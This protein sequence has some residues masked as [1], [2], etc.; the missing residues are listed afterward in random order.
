MRH[1]H[2]DFETY[3]ETDIKRGLDRY[4]ADPAF[5]ILMCA[6]A[7]DQEPVSLIDFTESEDGILA[8]SSLGLALLDTDVIICAHNAVFEW[9][10]LRDFGCDSPLDRFHCT[11]VQAYSLGFRG[12]LGDIQEQIGMPKDVQKLK[13]GQKLIQR[14]SKPAPSNHKAHRYDKTTHPKE[15]ELFKQ[16]C[17][18]DVLA[19]R[20]LQHWLDQYPI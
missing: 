15:W 20:E 8:E 17:K 12:S 19:E 11:Q 10:C 18:Q 16:Y 13:T 6:W 5:E 2:L 4:F 3:S 7:V 1:L 9:Y 14:F